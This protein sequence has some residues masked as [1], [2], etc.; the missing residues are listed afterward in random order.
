MPILRIRVKVKWMG[1]FFRY[2]IVIVTEAVSSGDM[3]ISI[4]IIHKSLF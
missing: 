4:Q 3:Y 2:K 1:K